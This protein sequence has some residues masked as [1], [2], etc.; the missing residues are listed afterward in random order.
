MN[1]T[2][3]QIVQNGNNSNN[4]MPI[5]NVG[6]PPSHNPGPQFMINENHQ[7]GPPS[8]VGP[9]A[10]PSVGPPASHNSTQLPQ[11][12]NRHPSGDSNDIKPYI[13]EFGQVRIPGTKSTVEKNKDKRER[14][15]LAARRCRQRK[16]DKIKTLEETVSRM[17]GVLTNLRHTLTN[18]KRFAT[19]NGL[20]E[21]Q[22]IIS[23]IDLNDKMLQPFDLRRLDEELM[24]DRHCDELDDN[25]TSP[26]L[27]PNNFFGTPDSDCEQPKY[28]VKQEPMPMQ[29]L[30]HQ[31]NLTEQVRL[32][33]QQT[34]NRQM[35]LANQEQKQQVGGQG[36]PQMVT[37]ETHIINGQPFVTVSSNNNSGLQHHEIM[38]QQMQQVGAP[39][40]QQ[41]R[42]VQN[43]Q[44]M[45][46]Q[47]VQNGQQQ[48]Q[49]HPGVQVIQQ[50]HMG[51]NGQNMGQKIVQS[52]NGQQVIVQ[53]SNNQ[54]QT[55]RQQ[56]SVKTESTTPEKANNS[57]LPSSEAERET[58]MLD[59]AL[60]DSQKSPE[61]SMNEIEGL[62]TATNEEGDSRNQSLDKILEETSSE[63]VKPELMEDPVDLEASLEEEE[64]EEDKMVMPA[65]SIKSPEKVSAVPEEKKPEERSDSKVESPEKPDAT[66]STTTGDSNAADI[67]KELANA[68][69]KSKPVE[70]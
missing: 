59:K 7:N 64:L 25:F 18:V 11:L 52:S 31:S 34:A 33:M 3:N 4:S 66:K 65:Q 35:Q 61:M 51:Q 57:E 39:P 1:Q 50:S 70:K 5:Q 14:N 46:N 32:N 56:I 6:P 40:Q 62:I 38:P 8:S 42:V 21:L 68:T 47:V 48:Q 29:P 49:Q 10:P 41:M 60:A 44:Q 22:N 27:N 37:H 9:P 63:P 15:K 43:N 19:D 28:E 2:Q 67:T 16:M 58:S 13:D 20:K 45:S 17:N 54:P 24:S 26:R 55:P 53:M 12:T 36:G 23:G 30:F 69:Q